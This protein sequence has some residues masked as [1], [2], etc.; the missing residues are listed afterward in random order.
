MAFDRLAARKLDGRISGG[1]SFCEKNEEAGQQIRD[2]DDGT[3]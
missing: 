1:S 2:H 3:F